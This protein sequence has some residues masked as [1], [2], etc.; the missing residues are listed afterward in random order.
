[1]VQ[2]ITIS[3]VKFQLSKFRFK[4]SYKIWAATRAIIVEAKVSTKCI[5]KTQR[6]RTKEKTMDMDGKNI[7]R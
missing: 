4:T 2:S 6:C 3:N 7:D 1:M 5:L